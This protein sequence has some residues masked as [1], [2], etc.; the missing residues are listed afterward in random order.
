MTEVVVQGG[1]ATVVVQNR[2]PTTTVQGRGNTTQLAQVSTPVSV[3]DGSPVV[4]AT[5][6]APTV[7]V[8]TRIGP[9]GLRGEPGAD[10][11]MAAYVHTQGSAATTWTINH[12]LG[13]RPSVE[14]Y[15]VGGIEFDGD[16]QHTSENQVVVTLV[17]ATAGSARL[18]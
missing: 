18:I 6:V 7:E 9:R 14:L 16:V 10:G 5:P 8:G 13:Y 11:L 15:T 12:N 3:R 4:V 1:T 2:R 17:V